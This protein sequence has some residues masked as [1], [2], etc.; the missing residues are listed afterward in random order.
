MTDQQVERE[1]AERQ[2]EEWGGS[3]VAEQGRV[4]SRAGH[5]LPEEEAAG[6]DDPQ[7]QAAAIL[8]DSDLREGDPEAALDTVL[9]RRTSAETVDPAEPTD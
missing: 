9:E 8:A 6:S 1:Q 3:A 7:A 2:P 5:L 4:S